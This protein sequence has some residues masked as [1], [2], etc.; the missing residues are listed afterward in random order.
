MFKRTDNGEYVNLN[1]V[2]SIEMD[3]KSPSYQ[4]PYRVVAVTQRSGN[5]NEDSFFIL[6]DCK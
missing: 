6:K 3:V 1:W 5:I 4:Y 2:A